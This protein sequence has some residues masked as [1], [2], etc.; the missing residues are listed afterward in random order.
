MCASLSPFLHP[1]LNLAALLL[2]NFLALFLPLLV[3]TGFRIILTFTPKTSTEMILASA[4]F[5]QKSRITEP[6]QP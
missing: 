4:L 6:L 5:F 2:K 1:S 3:L